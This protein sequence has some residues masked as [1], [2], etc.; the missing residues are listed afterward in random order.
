MLYTEV[1]FL[2]RFERARAAG[3]TAVEFQFPYDHP[4][5]DVARAIAD[6]GVEVV[7][8]NMPAGDFAAGDRGMANDPSRTDDFRKSLTQA[9]EYAAAIKPMTM[10]CMAGKTLPDV[11]VSEQRKALIANLRL[12]ADAAAERGIRMVTEPLNPYDAPGFFL[13]KP[14]DGFSVVMEA[15]HPNLAV[16][17]DIYHAQRTEGNIVTAISENVANIGHIQIADSPARNEPGTGELSW[18]F[19][20]DQIDN[21]GY[22][23]WVGLEYKPSRGDT[24]A[25]LAWTEAYRA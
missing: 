11:S 1:P 6:A 9:M 13:P 23:G 16:E 10:N 14:S 19:I 20:F 18:E 7:L 3:F 15:G 25:S 17:Y 21:S 24:D 22:S 4:V 8:F 2:D 5:D 12:A